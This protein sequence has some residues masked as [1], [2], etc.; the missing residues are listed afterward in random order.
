MIKLNAGRFRTLMHSC[1]LCLIHEC[2]AKA[3]GVKSGERGAREEEEEEGEVPQVESHLLADSARSQ[4]VLPFLF[5]LPASLIILAP[6][7]FFCLAPTLLSIYKTLYIFFYSQR[8]RLPLPSITS[9]SS[10]PGIFP[11]LLSFSLFTT[12]ILCI[13]ILH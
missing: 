9:V 5:S 13:H 10:M 6:T 7:L 12:H 8:L 1:Q 3:G 2:G 4:K 11:R